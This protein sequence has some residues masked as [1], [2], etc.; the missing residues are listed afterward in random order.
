VKWPKSRDIQGAI[1]FAIALLSAVLVFVQIEMGYFNRFY[2][3]P[4]K[5]YPYPHPDTHSAHMALYRDCG[6][7]LLG[8]FVVLFAV[9]RLLMVD[10]RE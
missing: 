6:L 2:F 1:A 8:V 5:A 9:Q 3:A 7:T 10:R 4:H